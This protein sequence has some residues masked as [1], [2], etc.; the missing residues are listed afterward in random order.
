MANQGGGGSKVKIG[1]R[2][3]VSGEPKLIE[4]EQT[5]RDELIEWTRGGNKR[6]N[7]MLGN[8]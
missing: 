3:E 4:K 2:A 7:I 6:E 1:I 5:G 8:N